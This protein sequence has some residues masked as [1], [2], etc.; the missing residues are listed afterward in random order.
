M[1]DYAKIYLNSFCFTFTH[2]NPLS[3][4]T[5]DCFLEKL[6]FDFFYSGWKYLILFFFCFRINIF[7]SKTSNLLYGLKEPEGTV[8]CK[9][10]STSEI[11]NKYIY[12]AFPMIYLFLCCFFHV[13]VRQ[14][15]ESEIHLRLRE[16][17]QDNK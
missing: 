7:E 11:P 3:T 10:Y 8:G 14:R 12:D 16:E 5:I 17:V 13:L 1:P 2:C 4:R 9:S 15:S 6:K